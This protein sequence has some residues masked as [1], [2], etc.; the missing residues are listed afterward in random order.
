MRPSF[1]WRDLPSG[2]VDWS[3]SHVPRIVL[4]LVIAL[5]LLRSGMR[6]LRRFERRLEAQDART[7][8]HIN[9]SAT[10]I[11]ILGHILSITVW[12]I[13]LLQV[14]GEIG[15]EIGPMIAGAGLVGVALGFGAQSLVRDFLT[16]FFVLLEDQYSVGDRVN[17]DGVVGIVERF[18]LRLTSVRS[19]DGTLHHISN[20][21]IK[22]ASNTSAGWSRAIVD[23]GVPH[24]ENLDKVKEALLRAGALLAADDQI[25]PLVQ[26]M[27]EIMGVEE[28]TESQLRVRVAINTVPG[29]QRPVARAYRRFVKEVF[30]EEGIEMDTTTTL[31]M[32]SSGS[33]TSVIKDEDGALSRDQS[34]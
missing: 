10:L 21:N 15:I 16:G 11:S 27:P 19:I 4:T 26:E 24:T 8:R 5:I 7:D 13:A 32:Q 34:E 20:G 18:S 1:D 22:I 25:G 9:R 23:V 33:G 17:I 3:V 12:T 14:L 6:L 28:F 30:D 31:V 29:R 2:L